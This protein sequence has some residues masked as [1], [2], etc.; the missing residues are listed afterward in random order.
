MK[1]QSR[2]DRKY[3]TVIGNAYGKIPTKNFSKYALRL[4]PRFEAITVEP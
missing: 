3:V 2:R 4:Y 1:G